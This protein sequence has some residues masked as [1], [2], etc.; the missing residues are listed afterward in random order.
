MDGYVLS[1]PFLKKD[2]RRK[3][4]EM[5]PGGDF[6]WFGCVGLG[7]WLGSDQENNPPMPQKGI[8]V[9]VYPRPVVRKKV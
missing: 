1:V 5:L 6:G 8:S 2:G 3:Q 4:V 7:F 9:E